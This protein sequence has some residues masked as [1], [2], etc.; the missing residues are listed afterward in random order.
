MPSVRTLAISLALFTVAGCAA[1]SDLPPDLQ[2][3]VADEGFDLV[4]ELEASG[5]R[6]EETGPAAQA[7][8]AALRAFLD[9]GQHLWALEYLNPAAASEDASRFS[10]DGARYGDGN[11][12]TFVTWIGPPHL[13]H[14]GRW[15]ALYVGTDAH[16]IDALTGLLGNQFAGAGG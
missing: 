7:P 12:A 2:Q 4:R 6:L 14:R 1:P 9:E 15:I 13:F 16:I 3:G 8:F 5:L 11:S 10:A